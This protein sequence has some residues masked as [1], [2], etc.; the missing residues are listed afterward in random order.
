MKEIFSKIED[1]KLNINLS[2]QGNMLPPD[3][4][5]LAI[6]LEVAEKVIVEY[7]DDLKTSAWGMIGDMVSRI[8]RGKLHVN[9]ASA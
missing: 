3:D 4:V 2:A 9:L 5:D 1:D 7:R 8:H 6:F